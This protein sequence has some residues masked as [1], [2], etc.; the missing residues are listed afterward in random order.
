[1]LQSESV[2]EEI[3]EKRRSFTRA[4]RKDLVV[5]EV[6]REDGVAFGGREKR[7][8]KFEAFA[9]E[10]AGELA[11][12]GFDIDVAADSMKVKR[13]GVFERLAGVIF[14]RRAFFAGSQGA[15]HQLLFQGPAGL[16]HLT[17][18]FRT[19]LF[20]QQGVPEF[21]GFGVETMRDE[22]G[23]FIEQVVVIVGNLLVADGEEKGGF[24][25]AFD[26]GGKDQFGLG[27]LLVNHCS[28]RL[29][30]GPLQIGGENDAGLREQV[31]NGLGQGGDGVVK[32]LAQVLFGDREDQKITK[33]SVE[34]DHFGPK[35]AA[36]FFDR[37]P[38]LTVMWKHL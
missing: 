27:G 23:D 5:N 34:G 38:R 15:E 33:L 19:E 4:V 13:H 35:S 7:F 3:R 31:A 30:G 11:G 21:L 2:N 36:E 26:V 22:G 24:A 9:D 32:V 25:F 12:A 37:R 14:K 16:V 10:A 18:N 20:P 29:G 28:L 1:V 17:M 6:F 8:Q